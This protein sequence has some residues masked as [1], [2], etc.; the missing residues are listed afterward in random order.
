MRLQPANIFTE[1]KRR[2]EQHAI[3]DAMT[4]RQSTPPVAL[5]S[6]LKDDASAKTL[7]LALW[8]HYFYCLASN[9]MDVWAKAGHAMIDLLAHVHGGKIVKRE[10]LERLLADEQQASWS[11]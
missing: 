2:A 4:G 11:K 7:L 8:D 5:P 10:E 6:L 1:A 9:R 3:D